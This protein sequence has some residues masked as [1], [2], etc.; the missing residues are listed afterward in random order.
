MRYRIKKEYF[1]T[2]IESN[3]LNEKR[4]LTNQLKSFALILIMYV[5]NRMLY[6]KNEWICLDKSIT[7]LKTKKKILKLIHFLHIIF[8]FYFYV[9]ENYSKRMNS[10]RAICSRSSSFKNDRSYF[11]K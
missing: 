1:F 6:T 3:I 9:T 8:K 2:Q 10:E 5:Q 4:G 7:F 11:H